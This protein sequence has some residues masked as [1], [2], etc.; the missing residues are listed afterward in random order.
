V[1]HIQRVLILLLHQ[2]LLLLAAVLVVMYQVKREFQVVQVAA[3]RVIILEAHRVQ[4]VA[5]Q[6]VKD[7]QEAMDTQAEVH[8]VAVAVLELLVLFLVGHQMVV[9]VAPELLILFRVL[10]SLM[11][12]AAAVAVIALE[13]LGVLAAVVMERLAHL[14]QPRLEQQIRGLAAVVGLI[15]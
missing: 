7:T 6:V 13:E 14:L 3:V 11:Q 8:Q 5:V 10:R 15:I 2:L 4:V 9:M 12:A 1:R